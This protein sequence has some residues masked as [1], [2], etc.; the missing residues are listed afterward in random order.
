VIGTGLA[1]ALGKRLAF[2]D[3]EFGSA[4]KYADLF[5]FDTIALDPPFHPDRA[6]EAIK[7]AAEA[8]YGA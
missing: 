2:V 5:D 6:V 4:A 7:A 1:K 8:G 3:T